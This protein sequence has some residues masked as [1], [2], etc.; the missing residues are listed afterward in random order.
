M[1]GF[2]GTR[3]RS[4]DSDQ[5]VRSTKSTTVE[6]VVLIFELELKGLYLS[7]PILNCP[8]SG[9]VPKLKIGQHRYLSEK[10]S[11]KIAQLRPCSLAEG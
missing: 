8:I 10:S 3:P 2:S 11:K 6:N 5:L 4:N 7:C 9:Q 1:F